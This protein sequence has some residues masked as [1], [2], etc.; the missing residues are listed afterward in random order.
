M[1]HALRKHAVIMD[2]TTLKRPNPMTQSV[3]TWTTR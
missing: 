2:E 1:Q 3:H